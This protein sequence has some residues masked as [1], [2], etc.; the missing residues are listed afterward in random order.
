[1]SDQKASKRHY[2]LM[3]DMGLIGRTLLG[4]LVID[5]ILTLEKHG[6]NNDFVTTVSLSPSTIIGYHTLRENRRAIAQTIKGKVH[7]L[8]A[9]PH[10]TL[11]IKRISNFLQQA[12]LF[13]ILLKDILLRKKVIILARAH[14]AAEVAIGLKKVYQKISVISVLEGEGAAEY[15]YN[16]EKR[17]VNIHS[18]NVK[19]TIKYMDRKEK[20]VILKSDRV[21]CVSNAYKKHLD[22]KHGLKGVNIGVLPGGADSDK[23]YFD[24]NLRRQTREQLGIKDR[25]I[26]VYAGNMHPW[27]MFS[28]SIE[29][30]K[31]IKSIEKKAHF[32]ILTPFKD[33]A[34]A[35]INKM[36][37]PKN[38]YTLLSVEHSHM[39]AHLNA[40]DLGLLLRENHLL[41]K[42]ASPTKFSEYVMCGLPV[43]MSEGIGDYSET[44]KSQRFGM[45]IHDNENEGEIIKK[46]TEFREAG[47]DDTERQ[48]FS[49]WAT[50]L[51]SKENQLPVLLRIY[52]DLLGIKSVTEMTRQDI[53]S[54]GCT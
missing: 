34:M 53:S 28:R 49:E 33:E 25:F 45:V 51:F 20:E 52:S 3:E 9:L 54:F 2:I 10:I 8:L 48:K 6:I 40:A 14:G 4:S 7:L 19:G 22:E 44:M 11:G 29:V 39:P 16:M 46:F 31:I 30:F 21:L 17:G 37:L 41:N 24:E 38:D 50:S 26:L 15:E 12:S 5:I 35:Y 27:Q 23:F 1:M 42:V 47:L 18:K 43:M 36:H 32:L 13:L